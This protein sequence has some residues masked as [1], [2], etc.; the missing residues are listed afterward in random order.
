MV[1]K[2]RGVSS[3]AFVRRENSRSRD[4][5]RP[6]GS[7]RFSEAIRLATTSDAPGI[8]NIAG[9]GLLSLGQ[10]VTR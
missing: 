6:A 2:S 7:S 8:Y 1:S 10:A 5:I 4:T 9:D 3:P